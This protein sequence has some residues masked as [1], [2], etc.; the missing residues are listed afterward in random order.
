[1]VDEL[2]GTDFFMVQFF[3]LS[4]MAALKDLPFL[5][6]YVLNRQLLFLGNLLIRG[7]RLL[8]GRVES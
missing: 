7:L 4:L 2:T 1:M 6:D 3:Q 8:N 5:L